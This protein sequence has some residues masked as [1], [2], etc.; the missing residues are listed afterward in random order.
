MVKLPAPAKLN[1]FLH[2]T[3]RRADGYHLLQSLFCLIDWQDELQLELRKD[4]RMERQDSFDWP[5]SSDLTVR[6]AEALRQWALQANLPNAA[7][8]GCNIRMKKAIPAGAG[9]GG[10]SSDAASCLMGLRRLWSL[11]ISDPELKAIGLRLGADVPFFLF[12]E[13]ALAEGVGE[14]LTSQ[15]ISADWF[16]VAVPPVHVPTAAIFQSPHLERSAQ[17]CSK[18][19]LDQAQAATIWTLGSNTLEPVATA[20]FDA[21]RHLISDLSK[22]A[23]LAGLPRAATR[24]SGSG[25]AVFCSCQSQSQAVALA[26][27]LEKKVQEGTQMRVCRRLSKHPARALLQ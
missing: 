21:V 22:A 2:V 16:L 9:L 27:T 19:E 23:Q 15:Q 11:P 25:G 14:T 7:E 17:P 26:S 20:E 4:G 1:L 13:T 18:S 24:M 5:A 8:L 6:A 10:G 12:G 3:G